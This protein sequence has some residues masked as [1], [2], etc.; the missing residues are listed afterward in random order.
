M[1]TLRSSRWQTY[2]KLRVPT[3]LP[4]TFAAFKVASSA[5]VLGA[6]VAEWLSS[7]RG[8]GYVIYRSHAEAQV[9]RMMMGMVIACVMSIV[10]FVLVGLVQ[11]FAIPWH[12]SVIHLT[13]A[14][15]TET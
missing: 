11:R 8:L 15:E 14:L 12:R 2:W 3:A 4:L 13:S 6:V 1:H 5:S 10:A 9:P 7:T